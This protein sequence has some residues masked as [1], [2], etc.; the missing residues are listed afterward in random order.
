M[1]AALAVALVSDSGEQG[2]FVGGDSARVFH[3]LYGVASADLDLT[4]RAAPLHAVQVVYRAHLPMHGGALP[5]LNGM[6][7]RGAAAARRSGC[8]VSAAGKPP[9]LRAAVDGEGIGWQHGTGGLM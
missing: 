2:E 4:G 9:V 7:D 1:P 3:S 6:F 8:T 5:C